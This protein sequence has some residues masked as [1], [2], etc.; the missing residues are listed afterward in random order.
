MFRTPLTRARTSE[1]QPKLCVCMRCDSAPCGNLQSQ[2]STGLLPHT[3]VGLAEVLN[4]LLESS[5]WMA[6]DTVY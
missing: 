6:I 1:L 5:R 2:D 4:P 3:A